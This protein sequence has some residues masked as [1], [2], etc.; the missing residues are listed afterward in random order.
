MPLLERV[1][2]LIRA[3]LNDLVNRA[4]NPEKVLRQLLLDMQNQLLQ[5]KTQLAMAIADQ[6]LLEKKQKE[7]LE[8]QREWVAKAHLAMQKQEEDLARMA[9][10]RFLSHETAASNFEQQV[11]D[12]AHQVQLFRDAY[13]QLEQ[14][15]FDTKAQVDVLIAQH[16][17]AHAAATHAGGVPMAQEMELGATFERMKLKVAEADALAKGNLAV[18]ETG[19]EQR[20]T[21]MERA[22]QVERLL[23]DLRAK[24]PKRVE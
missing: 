23:Q 16:R 4:E 18:A 19:V 7:H 5:V 3:N 11:H 1:T 22:D 15:M 9:L 2:T 6:H 13:H 20:F 12:Q 24:L 17:R 14:K 8:A 21:A 10:E